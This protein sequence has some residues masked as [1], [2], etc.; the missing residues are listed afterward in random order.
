[1][2][3]VADR[4]MIIDGKLFDF[5]KRTFIM[6][7][8]NV[9]PDSFS[10][11]GKYID[12]HRAVARAMQMIEEGSDIIDVGG[13]STRPRGMY[14]EGAKKISAEEEVERVIP[15]IQ[16]IRS[17]TDAVIS[18]DT[19]KSTVAEEALRAGAS[20]VNDISGL[21]FDP[22]VASVAARY[23]AA[24][25]L[26]HIQGTPET[27]QQ[28]PTYAD[29]VHEVKEEL[30]QSIENAKSAS[31]E[32]IIVDPGIGFGKN[33]DHNLTLLKHLAEFQELGYP[34]LVGTSRKGFIGVL[35][36]LPVDQRIEGTAASVAV[37]I[38]NGAQIVRVHDVKE[39]KRI[40][41]IADAIKNAR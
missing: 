16:K 40:A 31:V 10:D 37:A 27:M 13:E 35:L 21:K 38:M 7:V 34:V 39:M 4:K 2:N 18:I 33:L 12:P 25:V 41:I 17:S 6:G 23:N 9:T 15:V 3:A 36:D 32:N 19:Y 30:R 11:G 5:T 1:M 22:A 26:M 8:L 20:I 28:N 24:L 14:G 29:V